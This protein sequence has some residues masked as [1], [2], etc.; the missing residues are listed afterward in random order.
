MAGT[1]EAAPSQYQYSAPPQFNGPAD[2]SYQPPSYDAQPLPPDP[3]PHPSSAATQSSE[4]MEEGELSEGQFEDLYEPVDSSAK[5]KDTI[6]APNVPSLPNE[7]Q[8]TSAV[9]TPSGGFYTNDG[10]DPVSRNRSSDETGAQVDSRASN[11]NGRPEPTAARE[12]SGSYSP[13][14]SPRE[15]SGAS[16][17][18]NL[19][20]S[21]QHLQKV[22][23]QVGS[24]AMNGTGNGQVPGLGQS[25]NNAPDASN[26]LTTSNTSNG[27]PATKPVASQNQ[28][29]INVN[30]DND[31]DKSSFMPGFKSLAEAKK[32]AQKAILRLWP[33][34]VKYQHYIDE[35][36]DEKVVKLL[37]NELHLDMSTGKPIQP[38]IPQQPQQPTSGPQSSTSATSKPAT[39]E[40]K[41]S[42]Q[43]GAKPSSSD[44]MDK[45]EERKDRIARLLAA[46]AA[47]GPAPAPAPASA[48]A[49]AQASASPA[50]LVPSSASKPDVTQAGVVAKTVTPVPVPAPAQGKTQAPVWAPSP[51]A[52]QSSASL[53][54]QAPIPAQV[55]PPTVAT[56][57]ITARSSATST[58]AG[59]KPKTKEEIERLLRQ[60]M[61][62]LQKSRELGAQ[63]T[64]GAE[65][66]N[67]GA[68]QQTATASGAG[69]T[70][71]ASPEQQS[72]QDKGPIPGLFLS[73][74]SQAQQ[75]INVRKRPVATD[76][77][78]YSS[79]E[80][81]KRPFGQERQA[82]SLVIDVSDGS[83]DEE[84]DIDM[85]MDSPTDTPPTLQRS[86]TSERK[87][88]SLAEFPPLRDL[89][90]RNVSSPAPSS[91]TPPGG[92]MS[93]K[94]KELLAKEKA[95]QEMRRKIAE[96]E[97]KRKAKNGS[98][99]PNQTAVTPPEANDSKSSGASDPRAS[100]VNV[101][102]V[103]APSA[104]LISE[105]VSAKLVKPSEVSRKDS[106]PVERGRSVSLGVP[107]VDSALEEK[108]KKL[109]AMR[110]ARAA[111]IREAE[112]RIKAE[113]AR[114]REEEARMQ[115]EEERLQAEFDGEA[116]MDHES[117][118]DNQSEHM[119]VDEPTEDETPNDSEGK[120][121]GDNQ[122]IPGPS[123]TLIETREKP[124]S[125][126][127]PTSVKAGE[128]E[129]TAH[130]AAEA[131]DDGTR[132]VSQSATKESGSPQADR[133][134]KTQDTA[135]PT[136]NPNDDTSAVSQQQVGDVPMIDQAPESTTGN[137]GTEPPTTSEGQ[138]VQETQPDS[139]KSADAV[140][141]DSAD[142]AVVLD[143]PEFSPEPADSG[144][145]LPE[146]QIGE[147]SVPATISD[148]PRSRDGTQEIEGPA[149]SEDK[150]AAAPKPKSGFMPYESPLRYFRAFK[151]HPE[152]KKL[153][154]GG[155]K[156]LTYSNKID[157]RKE[158]CPS[159]L[160]G[161]T[162]QRGKACEFQHL[163][164]IGVSDEQILVELGRADDYTGE[165]KSRFI[166]GLRE[167]LQNFRANKVRDFDTIAN[168]I[169]EFRS[170]FLGDRS[171]IL[172]LEGVT[173]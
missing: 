145:G 133:V 115:E 19:G 2:Q 73:S 62:A 77:V 68:P 82:S 65:T 56:P 31:N 17:P 104:Q 25:A 162:C 132:G 99:T 105:A 11:T 15:I 94:E 14:L 21:S 146:P 23:A 48:P 158:L 16:T 103:D 78:D 52:T 100:S 92:S 129:Q 124:S 171:R 83:D 153:V 34:G 43:S 33:L 58:P 123:T 120:Q 50:A 142:P 12:R 135:Q 165:Q 71:N 154:P 45:S 148:V 96:A 166:Q 95:I 131:Q 91:H 26:T 42:P 156:S 87:G 59:S 109:A 117:D 163:S 128:P 173:L 35:G 4:E 38:E 144:A 98:Q 1:R 84:M 139:N 108:K 32:E 119:S 130:A 114:I 90:R 101:D 160:Q 22:N 41:P 151:F 170:R 28:A 6:V 30:N 60:K 137:A 147:Q 134:D 27:M 13:Y 102:K 88:P 57:A 141:E 155:V 127:A 118:D 8:P 164:S 76:F 143:S 89:S 67:H 138:A 69:L 29:A 3:A 24:P 37:F 113:E 136:S 167:L 72:K 64:G 61:E 44:K 149:T 125:P 20:R 168:G 51:A 159:E 47:K 40:R 112:A 80:S 85:D 121:D 81:R 140:P 49:V 93:T 70:A 86:N 152:F 66:A 116:E 10:E 9:D 74:T 111:R 97:A 7:S 150:S 53:R 5:S 172:P 110:E 39:T 169:I 75:P 63:K 161:G 157:P 122:A 55:Q 18:G 106:G 126:T 54:A 107:R 36:F 46:K 79:L